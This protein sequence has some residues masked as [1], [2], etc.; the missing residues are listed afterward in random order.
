MNQ[1]L[2]RIDIQVVNVNPR[3]HHRK[4]L[5]ALLNIHSYSVRMVIEVVP[6]PIPYRKIV[7]RRLAIITD[8]RKEFVLGLQRAVRRKVVTK[9]ALKPTN[10]WQFLGKTGHA[11]AFG[12]ADLHFSV[13]CTKA[14]SNALTVQFPID[15]LTN[16]TAECNWR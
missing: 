13:A 8:T 6:C 11:R 1:P 2:Y 4:L 14:L 9:I 7:K 3:K 10:Q 5:A 15:P 12:L 16:P